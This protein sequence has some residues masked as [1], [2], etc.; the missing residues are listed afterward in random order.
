MTVVRNEFERGENSPQRVL[1]QHIWSMAF[2]AHP[3]H[4]STIGWKSDIENM[5]IEKL[6]EFYDTY[7][8]PNNATATIVG[9]VSV[10]DGLKMIK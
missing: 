3:Y 10:E 7:Y 8:W 9:D 5:S 2:Q 4:H 6:R 1:D